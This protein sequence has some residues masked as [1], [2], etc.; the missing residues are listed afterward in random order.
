MQQ[1]ELSH[2]PGRYA[3][4]FL[5]LQF[6]FM[7]L[8]F[9]TLSAA[10]N[11]PMSLDDPASVAL[12]RVIEQY[13]SMMFGYGCYF[14][15]GILLIPATVALNAR[16]NINGPLA[17]LT[18]ALATFSA[19]AK[20]IGITRW[21][22][23]MPP[24]AEAYLAPGA[25]RQTIAAIFEMLNAYAGSIGEIVGVGLISGI[26]TV[27]M[28]RELYRAP[29]KIVKTLSVFVF[30]TGLLLFCVIFDGWY[31]IDLGPVLSM[32]GILWQAGLFSI[33]LWALTTPRTE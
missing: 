8:A 11:W 21:L 28:A 3:A 15:V 4:F 23:A 1:A 5:I 30:F 14:L 31:G 7:G 9:S 18:V 16:L 32:S 20:T 19:V 10:I 27:L 29:G 26:W 22:F 17:T 24:L 12:P 6:L 25:D 13:P 33:G 2:Q